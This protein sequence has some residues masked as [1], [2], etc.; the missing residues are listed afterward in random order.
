MAARATPPLNQRTLDILFDYPRQ[1][2]PPPPSEW[3]VVETCALIFEQIKFKQ[4]KGACVT[5]LCIAS[6]VAGLVD[7]LMKK[8]MIDFDKII[9][10]PDNTEFR[11]DYFGT[12]LVIKLSTQFKIAKKIAPHEKEIGY[13]KQDEFLK[14]KQALPGH[15]LTFKGP[16]TTLS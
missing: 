4:A 5:P 8:Y 7:P 15:T 12:K 10:L 14:Y 1:Q 6:P 2:L 3:K 9:F 13:I 11:V 16:Y